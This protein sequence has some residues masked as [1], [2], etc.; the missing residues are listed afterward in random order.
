MKVQNNFEGLEKEIA[1]QR[2]IFAKTYAKTA[3]HEYIV[4][5][6]NPKLFDKICGLIDAEGYSEIWKDGKE[7]KYLK[8]GGY[9]YWHFDNILNRE[10]LEG[11]KYG[12]KTT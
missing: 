2:W 6:S 10:K 4:E 7:Y 3:P 5:K 11:G 9:K 8:I 12:R 1:R